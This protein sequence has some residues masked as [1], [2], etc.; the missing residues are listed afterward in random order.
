[1]E[2]PLIVSY[3][4]PGKHD[5]ANVVFRVNGTIEYAEYEVQVAKDG[6]S[7]LFVR[8]IHAK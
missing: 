7:I 6:R 4:P 1:V 2:D 5:Y 3:H 8:A